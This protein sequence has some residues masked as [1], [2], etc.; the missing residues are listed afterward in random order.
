MADKLL[1]KIKEKK[2]SLGLVEVLDSPEAVETLAFAGMDWVC[3]DMMFTSTDWNRA[4]HMVRAA[5]A[6]GTT[7]LIRVPCNPWATKGNDLHLAVDITRAFGINATGV[8][9]SPNTTREV[10]IAIE[11]GKD[12]HHS[13]HIVRF[14]D[15]VNKFTKTEEEIAAET[16]VMPLIEGEDSVRNVADLL[17]VDGL[18]TACLAITDASRMLGHPLQYEHPEVWRWI[19][20]AANAAEKH[21]VVLGGNTG[22]QFQTAVDIAKRIKRLY[23]HGIRIVLIQTSGALLQ[24]FCRDIIRSAISEVGEKSS[25]G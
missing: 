15:A 16:V 17:S 13:I 3:I 6:A 14:A 8:V 24:F 2:L 5:R 23:D 9:F 20:K 21:G 22:Y 4:A 1:D 18:K 7:P 10:E 25:K 12:W 19:D 11:V